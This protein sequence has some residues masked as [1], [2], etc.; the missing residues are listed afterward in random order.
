MKTK[1]KPESKTELIDSQGRVYW[2][3]ELPIASLDFWNSPTQIPNRYDSGA[4]DEYAFRMKSGE[5]DW[6]RVDSY[7][8]IFQEITELEEDG[9]SLGRKDRWIGDGHHTLESA[10][11]AEKE[12]VRCKIYSGNLLDA[13][14][15]SFKEANR[16]HGVRLT[17]AQKREIVEETLS[18][19]SLL[20]RICEGVPGALAEDVPSER[21][22]ATYLGDVASPPTVGEIWDRM[23]DCGMALELPWLATEKRLGQD[24]KRQVKK[25][26][27]VKK[28]IENSKTEILESSV[29]S[30][31]ESS[32][33]DEFDRTEILVAESDL[34][35]AVTIAERVERDGFV[36]CFEAFTDAEMLAIAEKHAIDTVRTILDFYEVKDIEKL[37]QNISQSIVKTLT[38]YRDELR[39]SF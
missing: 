4:V 11:K 7:P 9:K 16:F 32:R 27:K 14:I 1:I 25:V 22:I 35:V 2:I 21:L 20:S 38:D 37:E 23:L 10:E 28:P 19:R 30:S 31:V 33:S 6:N 36:D 8:V 13:K 5:W 29:E 39:S 17:N 24:G 26:K 34:E 12:T 18:D 3:E 15:Y